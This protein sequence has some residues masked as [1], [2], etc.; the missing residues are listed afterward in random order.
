MYKWIHRVWYEGSP[1]YVL[2]L[3]LSGVYYLLITLRGILYRT[4]VFKSH[5]LPVPVLVV[6]N[7]T[8]G[9]TGKTPTTI[10]LVNELRKRGF[11]PGIVSRGY[12]GS[13]SPASMRVDRGSDPA[14]VGDEPVLVAIRA[15]CPVVV[16]A[17]RCRAARMLIEDGVDLIIA[18]DGL[19][20]YRLSRS[21]E[22]CV[23]DAARGLGNRLLFPAGPL[24]EPVSRL[25]QVDQVLLNG[26][27]HGESEAIEGVGDSAIRFELAAAEVCRLNGSLTRPIKGFSDTTVHA[28]AGIGNPAR[29]FGML[30]THGIQV[31]EH[32]F[33]D[34]AKIDK[35]DLDF[36]DDFDILMTEKDAV[37]LGNTMSD[38]FWFVPVNFIMETHVAGP[39]L[40]QID[41]RL[42]TE[43]V[44][45]R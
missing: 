45:L 13:K 6:G 14:V 19:Q 34:H 32:P 33:P 42:R 40:E 27:M 12:G 31:I 7:I 39:W 23:I 10:W 4:G 11:S 43:L 21:Y 30:R 38:K 2:L 18:D 1:W 24:R 41:S 20:H 15:D 28:V 25:E 36:G 16:D 29:F 3:P 22:I 26:P 37:K 5:R 9:G 8:A 44:A 35:A 17:D